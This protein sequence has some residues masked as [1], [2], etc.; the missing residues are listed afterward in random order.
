MSFKNQA[1]ASASASVGVSDGPQPS[2]TPTAAPPLTTIFTPPPQC[3]TPLAFVGDCQ[4]DLECNGSFMPFLFIQ[5]SKTPSG[6]L[7]QCYPETTTFNDGYVDAVFDYSPGIFCPN[8]MTT[9]TSTAGAFLCCP[10]GLT[11]SYDGHQDQCT[12]TLTMGE[13]LLGPWQDNSASIASTTTF[14]AE[15]HMT[16]YVK[17][18]PIYLT[19][20]GSNTKSSTFGDVPSQSIP[21]ISGD[22]SST[23]ISTSSQASS[24]T[25]TNIRTSMSGQ[26]SS[27]TPAS[28]SLS[29]TG[30]STPSMNPLSS[31]RPETSNQR[32]LKIGIGVGVGG[33]VALIL[34][35]LGCML[36]RRYRRKRLFS[37]HPL[38]D[39][40][41][42]EPYG[43]RTQAAQQIY[44]KKPA[45]ELPVAEPWAELEGTRVEEHGAGIYVWKPELEGTAGTP[46]A[47]G[48]KGVYVLK[49]SEL[50]AKY[51]NAAH[52]TVKPGVPT[53]YESPIIGASF[54][55]PGYPAPTARMFQKYT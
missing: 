20:Q 40:P 17:A 19:A 48:A 13:A 51:N 52:S 38:L 54:A 42:I 2:D 44:E 39:F 32:N 5:N 25:P 12:A 41:P 4:N 50:E 43:S 22:P 46:G 53:F 11:Y 33:A 36:L 15:E 29:T 35:A 47:K 37:P 49:K 8:G 10:S 3:K 27:D 45:S 24:D 34:L 9:A 6:T 7:I 55:S 28:S 26:V 18:V 14:S 16:L 1:F 21:P 23:G 30:D 31:D